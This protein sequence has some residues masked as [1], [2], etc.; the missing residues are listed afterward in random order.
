MSYQ[1]FIKQKWLATYGAYVAIQV[2]NHLR[3]G[4]ELE[5]DDM[6][7]FVMEAETVADMAE[8]HNKKV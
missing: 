6:E 1:N 3:D 8:E 7:R 2:N 4:K 5:P